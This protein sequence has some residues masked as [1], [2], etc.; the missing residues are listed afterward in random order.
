LVCALQDYQSTVEWGCNTTDLPSV[1][2]VAWNNGNPA[3]P[4]AEIGDGEANTNAILA[5]CTSAP[6]ALAARSYGAEWF[7][8]SINELKEM[9]INRAL[10]EAVSGFDAFSNSYWSSTEYNSNGHNVWLKNFFND[11][12]GFYY[13]GNTSY[14]R[15][16]RAF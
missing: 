14:V 9:Y 6:A 5:D 3:G 1:P 8:P 16:V 10:L 4:G 2:N 15:A 7:L 12:Q 13:K 11:S